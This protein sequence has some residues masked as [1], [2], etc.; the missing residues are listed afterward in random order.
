MDLSCQ[1]TDSDMGR[2]SK[3]IHMGPQY[4]QRK[5]KAEKVRVM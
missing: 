4:S 2:L 3:I 1:P 5:R